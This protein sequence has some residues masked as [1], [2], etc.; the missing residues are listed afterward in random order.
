MIENTKEF[1]EQLTKSLN[2]GGATLAT[3]GIFWV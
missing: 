3:I 1:I 2:C